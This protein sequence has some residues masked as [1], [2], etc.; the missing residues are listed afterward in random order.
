MLV[1]ITYKQEGEFIHA[2]V[3]S[4]DGE[5]NFFLNSDQKMLYSSN[6]KKYDHYVSRQMRERFRVEPPTPVPVLMR[7]VIVDTE[8]EVIE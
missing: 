8:K 3:T 7:S 6:P 2:Y 4:P 5:W 1:T